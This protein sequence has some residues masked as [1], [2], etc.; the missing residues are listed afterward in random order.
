M[1]KKISSLF[2]IFLFVGSLLTTTLAQEQFQKEWNVGVS[3]GT[4]LSQASFANSYG[5]N[6]FKTKMWQQY[7]GGVAVR[8]ISEKNLGLIAELNYVQ[9]GWSQDFVDKDET[10]PEIIAQQKGY[11]HKHQFNYIEVPFL[12]HVYFGNK[13]RFFFNL[14]PRFSF[15]LSDKETFN[16]SLLKHLA[17]GDVKYTEETAQFFRK[18]DRK[19]DYGLMGGLGVEFRTGIGNF[20]LEGRY[21]FGL[22][23]FFSNKKSDP[24]QRSAHRVIGVKLNYFIKLF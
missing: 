3:F 18:A 1:K 9:Q 12:M 2:S 20:S 6:P 4:T 22:G 11:E 17:S 7:Q 21:N 19:F 15:L 14:G 23:D 8:Y 16:D 24:F 13:V 10:N 5:T